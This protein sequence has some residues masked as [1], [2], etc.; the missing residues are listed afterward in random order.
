MK[1]LMMKQVDEQ[2]NDEEDIVDEEQIIDEVELN[3]NGFRFNVGDDSDVEPLHREL[4]ITENGLEVLDFDSFESDVGD[5]SESQGNATNS[6]YSH[7]K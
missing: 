7:D 5:D 6:L 2:V 4:N 3:M 1:G